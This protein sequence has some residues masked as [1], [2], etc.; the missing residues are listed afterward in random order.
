[1]PD[2]YGHWVLRGELSRA[3]I[4]K[5][6]RVGA[7]FRRGLPQAVALQGGREISEIW[8]SG[9]TTPGANVPLLP[10]QYTTCCQMAYSQMLGP[11]ASQKLRILLGV[12]KHI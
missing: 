2:Y 12:L 11:L 3:A 10:P 7:L 9:A 5:E 4:L 1:M 8:F 6:L